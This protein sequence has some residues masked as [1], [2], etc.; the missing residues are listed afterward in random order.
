MS[1][2]I[3][4][5]STDELELWDV[6]Y[7]KGRLDACIEFEKQ[8]AN[9]GY[10]CA[11]IAKERERKLIQSAARVTPMFYTSL[12]DDVICVAEVYKNAGLEELK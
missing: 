4:P 5:L 6:A 8:L 11:D 12:D 3:K 9:F 2:G 1:E 7:A 10:V